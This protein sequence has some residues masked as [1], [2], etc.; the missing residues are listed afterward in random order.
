MTLDELKA[1]RQATEA[2][3]QTDEAEDKTD[4]FLDHGDDELESL[5]MLGDVGI[6]L[7]RLTDAFEDPHI[8]RVVPKDLIREVK[9]MA[10]TVYVYLSF[11]NEEE[12]E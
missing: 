1:E 7:D 11:M 4:V 8:A 2:E 12:D 6:L 10:E 5:E 3:P 9:T